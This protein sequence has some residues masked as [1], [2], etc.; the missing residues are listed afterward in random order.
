MHVALV[1]NARVAPRIACFTNFRVVADEYCSSNSDTSAAAAL[2]A[3]WAVGPRCAQHGV[4]T[5]AIPLMRANER[6]SKS[7]FSV[8]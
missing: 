8:R 7:T 6:T 4:A 5:E 2:P 1:L 3:S